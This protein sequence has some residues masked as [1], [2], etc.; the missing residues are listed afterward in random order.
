MTCVEIPFR[1]ILSWIVPHFGIGMSCVYLV[2]FFLFFFIMIKKNLTNNYDNAIHGWT[3]TTGPRYWSNPPKTNHT[4]Q[5]ATARRI[6]HRVSS[7]QRSVGQWNSLVVI[8]GVLYRKAKRYHQ[9]ASILQLVVPAVKRKE[10][11]IRCHEGMTGGHRA[12]R[13]TIDQVR[14]RG[15]WIRWRKDVERYCRQS[16][17]CSWWK[18]F[19]NMTFNQCSA[20]KSGNRNTHLTW[21]S[22][23]CLL[24]VTEYNDLDVPGP[25]YPRLTNYGI[26]QRMMYLNPRSQ[27][28]QVSTMNTEFNHYQTP[29]TTN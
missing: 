6:H 14:R 12:F 26:G 9:Q 29:V 25:S 11:I 3:L 24:S 16:E 19:S 20:A 4:K 7:Y 28:S 21:S 10:F 22:K 17:N 13:T 8:N 15:Y 27:I 2:F 1:H 23:N 18:P 5:S